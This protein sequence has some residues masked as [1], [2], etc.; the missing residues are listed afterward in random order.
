MPERNEFLIIPPEDKKYK[1]VIQIHARGETIH[2]DLRLQRENDLIGWTLLVQE[3]GIIKEP[4][5]TLE[6]AK[7]WYEKHK[8]D[9][10]LLI[11]KNDIKKREIKGGI[12]RRAS[13]QVVPKA[14]EPMVWLYESKGSDF[15]IFVEGVAPIGTPGSTANYPGVFLIVD[16]G[17]VEYGSQRAYM[18]EYF[19]NGKLQGR[20][21]IRAL[22]HKEMKET[23][24][25]PA[26]APEETE[27]RTTF[28]WVLIKPDDQRPYVLG[29]T[30]VQEGWLPPYNYSALPST[31]KKQVPKELQY[32]K[33]KDRLKAHKLRV[34]V[35]KLYDDKVLKYAEETTYKLWRIWWKRHDKEGKPVVVIRWGPSTEVFLFKI[36]NMVFETEFNPLAS[37]TLAIKRVIKT[38]IDDLKEKTIETQTELN[39]TKNTTC[40]MELIAQGKAKIYINNRDFL[41]FE[42]DNELYIA[43]KEENTNFWTISTSALPLLEKIT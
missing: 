38:K 42:I 2:L 9:M 28:Y 4:I 29:E 5:T 27:I 30:A 22:S 12:I 8:D 3:P 35:A 33:V 23:I 21:F 37:E 10:K 13:I 11:E 34:E 36:G 6:Q 18:H 19:F 31:L 1:Y 7:E 26:E 24:L 16:K 20:W 25:P 14:P 41:K 39:P 40:K 43:K 32:W 17:F 15:E